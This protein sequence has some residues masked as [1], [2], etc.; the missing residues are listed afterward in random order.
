MSQWS[1]TPQVEVVW[2]GAGGEELEVRS[3]RWGARGEELTQK[4]Q[5]P[6]LAVVGLKFSRLTWCGSREMSV[7]A[8]ELHDFAS[9][10]QNN[11]PRSGTMTPQQQQQ[12]KQQQTL[13]TQLARWLKLFR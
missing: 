1:F 4:Q 5:Q 12:Q 2:W 7:R 8:V 6:V 11:D 9:T 13:V 10:E 3:S